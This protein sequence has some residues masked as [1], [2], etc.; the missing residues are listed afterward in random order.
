M[1]DYGQSSYNIFKK[2]QYGENGAEK[3]LNA[4]RRRYKQTVDGEESNNTQ[5]AAKRFQLFFWRI[6]NKEIISRFKDVMTVE[7]F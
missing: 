6:P 7:M 4:W 1:D 5:K 2:K 3:I